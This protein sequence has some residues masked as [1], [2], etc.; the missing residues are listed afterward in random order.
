MSMF[1]KIKQSFKNTTNPPG[2][3]QQAKTALIESITGIN[4]PEPLSFLRKNKNPLSGTEALISVLETLQAA[5]HHYTTSEAIN[6]K[7][8]FFTCIYTSKVNVQK[9]MSEL[10]IVIDSIPFGNQIMVV[11]GLVMEYRKELNM[12]NHT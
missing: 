4:Y 3:K 2:K 10:E 9:A 7:Q 8:V 1:K 5:S 6:K 11:L 12:E